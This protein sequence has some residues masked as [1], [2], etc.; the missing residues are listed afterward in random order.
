MGNFDKIFLANTLIDIVIQNQFESLEKE[1]ME[2]L[3]LCCG[4]YTEFLNPHQNDSWLRVFQKMKEYILV[5]ICDYEL[6][7]YSLAILLNFLT[8][9]QL[10]FQIYEE[11]RDIFARSLGILYSSEVAG[12][13]K[14]KIC[15]DKFREFL[16]VKVLNRQEDSDNALKKFFKSLLLKFQ[17]ENPQEFDN[18]NVKDMVD[19]L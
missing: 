6:C 13:E 10:K 7:E 2:I 4:D 12:D 15:Q 1:H 19:Q 5:S 8:A 14:N 9:E 3:M 11:S 18:S 16:I 17:E